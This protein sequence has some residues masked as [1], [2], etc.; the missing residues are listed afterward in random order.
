MKER[1]I[2]QT[3]IN[4]INILI[5]NVNNM[6]N[7]KERDFL[8]L[9]IDAKLSFMYYA[10]YIKLHEYQGLWKKITRNS[11]KRYQRQ[12]EM[13]TTFYNNNELLSKIYS[14]EIEDFNPHH[15][16]KYDAK[17]N[18]DIMNNM[19]DSFLEYLDIKSMFKRI[20]ENNM[21]IKGSSKVIEGE[22]IDNYDELSYIVLGRAKKDEMDYYLNLIHEIGHAYTN[23]VLH[24]K[25][26][27][28]YGYEIYREFISITFV[29]MFLNYVKEKKVMPSNKI[30]GIIKNYETVK[31][32]SL[33]LGQIVCETIKEISRVNHMSYQK[34]A[35]IVNSISEDIP[36][37]IHYSSIGHIV[38]SRLFNEYTQ[39]KEGFIENLPYL[40]HDISKMDF[41]EILSEYTKN[42][43]AK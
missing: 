16:K 25:D 14:K 2:R 37:D 23:K 8:I 15:L 35:M 38:A 13:F 41:N 43:K 27:H 3:L 39:D 30:D 1:E 26:N 11:D 6:P 29:L 24:Q 36:V 18:P 12:N 42:E 22:C 5:R 21:F 4:E 10:E 34:Y 40:I 9:K 19:V 32:Y 20:K 17:V 28:F 31:K 7:S 33:Y